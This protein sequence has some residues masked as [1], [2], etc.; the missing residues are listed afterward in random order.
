MAGCLNC[1]NKDTC[2][3]CD[4]G[5]TLTNDICTECPLNCKNCWSASVCVTCF[6]RYVFNSNKQCVLAPNKNCMFFDETD[7]TQCLM[8]KPGYT[9]TAKNDCVRCLTG[10]IWSCSSQNISKVEKSRFELSTWYFN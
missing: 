2:Y 4:L 3:K 9:L 6:E 5:Y 1:K 7:T 10:S 8:C